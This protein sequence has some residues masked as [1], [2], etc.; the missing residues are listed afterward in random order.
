[1]RV[2]SLLFPALVVGTAAVGAWAQPGV[3]VESPTAGA[4]DSNHGPVQ[5]A[6]T[7]GDA[8]EFLSDANLTAGEGA[9]TTIKGYM[10]S[11]Q[12][13]QATGGTLRSL[14]ADVYCITITDAANF[15]AF[16]SSQQDFVLAL[17]D[18]NGVG[19]AFNDNRTDSA[20]SIASRLIANGLD[21]NGNPVGIAGLTNGTYFLGVSRNDG[22][23]A[24]RRFS[25]PLNAAGNLIF[26]G[27]PQGSADADPLFP[28]RRADLGPS[29][30]ATALA[31][32]ELFATA[33]APFTT[34]Y[35][36]TL[37]GAGYH[38]LPAPGA[39]ALL[40]LAG[41]GALRRRRR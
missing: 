5:T 27:P 17:F 30:P 20:T 23:T 7:F 33:A 37:T 2:R 18:M 9:L 14:D 12:R 22:G 6:P 39:S 24:A 21:V 26:P 11:F 16:T 10:S 3:W 15:A 32:W 31:S 4:G 40:G 19:V 35:T 38:Q 1:M 29:A 34:A 36:I 8:G 41:L 25:R 13:P 28:L